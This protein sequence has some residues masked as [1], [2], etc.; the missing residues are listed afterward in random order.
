[1]PEFELFSVAI[2]QDAPCGPDCEYDNDFLELTQ[3]VAGKPEQQFGDTVIAAVPPDWREVDRLAQALLARTRDLR[4][5]GWLTLA[6]THLEGATALAAGLKLVHSLCEQFW[7][8]VHPRLVVDGEADSFLRMSA[9]TAFSGS[10]FSG[11]DKLLQALRKSVLLK[12]PLSLSFRD[13]ESVLSGDAQAPITEEQLGAALRSAQASGAD[14]E[15]A[16]VNDAYES[17]QAL[18]RLLDERIS[19]EDRPDLERLESA[20]KT[21]TRGIRRF[22]SSADDA[23][24]AD[25]ADAGAAA[26]ALDAGGIAF[27]AGVIRSRED[28]RRALERVCEYLEQ[29]EPS[30]PAALFARRAQRMLNM[31]FLDIMRELAPDAVS[32]VEMVTGAVR[33]EDS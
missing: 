29:H 9:I 31:P 3:A 15:L 32:H 11:E 33:N 19:I 24:E 6:N 10:E 20:L 17:L 1:M 25:A 5:V 26:T 21:V 30:N 4:V 14:A 16:A 8:E 18:R 7:D 12:A 28:A 27:V 22:G 2:S 13:F 23:G